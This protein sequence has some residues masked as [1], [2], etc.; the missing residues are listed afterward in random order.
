[1]LSQ[2]KSYKYSQGIELLLF[3]TLF[4]FTLYYR[5]QHRN[6]AEISIRQQTT[7]SKLNDSLFELQKQQK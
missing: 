5:S 6:T 4:I 7:I 2:S 1:M 3:L